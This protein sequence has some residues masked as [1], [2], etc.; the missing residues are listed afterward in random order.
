MTQVWYRD[1]QLT[2]TL[3]FEVNTEVVS[4]KAYSKSSQMGK[5]GHI[6]TQSTT[7][8][9]TEM[10]FQPLLF[11]IHFQAPTSAQMGMEIAV[12]CVWLVLVVGPVGVPMTI[13]QSMQHTAP[14]TSTAQ[15]EVDPVWT[16]TH[17]SPWRSSV[18]DI[19]TALTLQMRTASPL[20]IINVSIFPFP[21]VMG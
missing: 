5:K 8:S 20:S 1:N 3:W 19:L 2:K 18:T 12:T 11:L 17:A 15:L 9:F 4:L 7:R 13:G 16:G 10:T 21:F 14:Q 6:F